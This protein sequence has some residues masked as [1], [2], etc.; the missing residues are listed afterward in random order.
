MEMK[1]ETTDG[2]LVA[3]GSPV[4]APLELNPNPR[5]SAINIWIDWPEPSRRLGVD[6][7]KRKENTRQL[8]SP[9]A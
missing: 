7:I 3:N 2:G 4:I 1:I 5:V 9:R 6:Y 8:L